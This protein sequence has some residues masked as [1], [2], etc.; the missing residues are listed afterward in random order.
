[1]PGL[2]GMPGPDGWPGPKGEPASAVDQWGRPISLAGDSG[3]D[4]AP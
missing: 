1:M 2:D 3:Y 4:G